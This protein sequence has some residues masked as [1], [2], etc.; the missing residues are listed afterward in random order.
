MEYHTDI[1]IYNKA[2]GQGREKRAEKSKS[3]QGSMESSAII[4]SPQ[5]YPC[6]WLSICAYA[7]WLAL[8]I[9]FYHLSKIVEIMENC[10]L[11]S[12]TIKIT[13]EL[14]LINAVKISK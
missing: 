9:H 2:W 7:S 13:E 14:W 12:A 4:V 8:H 3:S 11:L 10:N 1:C 6:L 5:F